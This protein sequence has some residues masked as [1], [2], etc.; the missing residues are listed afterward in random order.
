M[1]EN[2][3]KT[4]RLDRFLAEMGI[5]S[6]RE[7][8]EMAQKGRIRING[9]IEK[10][11]DRRVNPEEDRIEADGKIVEYAAVEYFM[12]NKPQGVVSATED[13][14]Y[15][16]VI[17][18]IDQAVRKDLFPVGRLDL[19]TEGLLLITN[20]GALAHRLLSPKKHVDKVY[21]AYVEGCLPEDAAAR[22]ECGI[23]MEDGWTALPA[24]LKVIGPVSNEKS[25]GNAPVT[26]V[27]LT[28]R[29]GK[30]HQVKRMFEALGCRVIYLKRLSMGP[31]KLDSSL[32][33]GEYRRLTREEIDLLQNT[34]IET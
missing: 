7:I 18:L 25:E 28:I 13:S 1:A 32:L 5:G 8:R 24:V 31:L 16:T 23:E 22:M 2:G 17:G 14:R 34:S 6:R 27:T 4:M 12:L 19:D 20:D 10:K 30:F 33:P 29:E 26:E 3:K 21:L 15:Q 11:S 9:E